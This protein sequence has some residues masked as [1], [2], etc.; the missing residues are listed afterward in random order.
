M[1]ESLQPLQ[2]L[3]VI[4]LLNLGCQQST[5]TP[6]PTS[7]PKLRT[8]P[9]EHKSTLSQAHCTFNSKHCG[10]FQCPCCH[11]TSS[12]HQKE[13]I[14]LPQ[15]LHIQAQG[16]CWAPPP[17]ENL[18]C[19]ASS[20]TANCPLNLNPSEPGSQYLT[21]NDAEDKRETQPSG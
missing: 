16:P 17:S 14:C 10:S 19:L 11:S 7:F 8:L 6:E 12:G 1:Y 4:G 15:P 2:N 20:S 21:S 9:C 18:R 13:C 3:Y 5:V